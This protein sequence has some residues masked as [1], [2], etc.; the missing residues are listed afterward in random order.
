LCFFKYLPGPLDFD[1]DFVSFG[2][3][4]KGFRGLIVA[5]D[6]FRETTSSK[7]GPPH[8][9]GGH[10]GK[11]V[12]QPRAAAEH[13]CRKG[14]KPQR[15]TWPETKKAPSAD[16]KMAGRRSFQREKGGVRQV[17]TPTTGL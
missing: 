14:L 2:G 8:R 12:N 3:P 16:P 7:Q 13:Q 17:R 1:P 6:V 15:V 10:V 4:H 11:N 5:G 9:W